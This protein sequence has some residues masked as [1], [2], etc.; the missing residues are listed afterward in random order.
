MKTLPSSPASSPAGQT[1]K[2]PFWL[3]ALLALVLLLILLGLQLAE[4]HFFL[5]DDNV[6]HFLPAYD[7]AYN[8]V[9]HAGE[10]PLLNHHQMFGGTFLASG[11][12]GVFLF[13][14]YPVHAAFDLLG[15]DPIH[16]IDVLAT[17][18][19]WLAG[20]GMGWLLRSWK[21]RPALAFPLALCWAL[22]PFGVVA[23]RS[24]VFVTF[25]IAYLPINLGLLQ[26]CLISPSAAACARLLAVKVVFFYTGYLHYAILA[27]FFEACFLFL[28]WLR[29]PHAGLRQQVFMMAAV[30]LITLLLTAPLLVTTWNAK[31]LS[32]QRDQPIP[33]DVAL[34][35][36]LSPIETLKAHFFASDSNIYYQ[37]SNAIFFTGPLWLV[38]LL[39]GWRFWRNL[40]ERE[41][42]SSLALASTGIFALLMSTSLYWLLYQLPIFNVLRWPFKGFP[43]AAF[44]LLLPAAS[45]LA[46]WAAQRPHR[47]YLAAGLVWLNLLLELAVLAPTHWRAPIGDWQFERTVKELRASPFLRAISDQ[48]RVA[49]LAADSD[50]KEKG[51]PLALG[52]LYATLFGKYHVHGYDPLK[53]R[54][55]VELGYQIANDGEM[56]VLPGEWPKLFPKLKARYLILHA[57]SDLLAEVE[58]TPGVQRL[59]TAEGLV[60]FEN[61]EALPIVSRAEEGKPIPFRW[62]TNGLELDLPPDFPGGHLLIVVAGLKGYRWYLDGE[63][64]GEPE[65]AYQLPILPV[66]PGAGHVELRYHDRGFVLGMALCMLGLL[67][68]LA[69]LRRGDA[70][71]NEPR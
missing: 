11:Q 58:T 10:I 31:E 69:G 60:L 55:N 59:K 61:L 1:S 37:L 17:L 8:T 6:T 32:W 7:Y 26:R 23:G 9:V 53:A 38:G 56:R 51:R 41:S 2:N 3:G 29:R 20:L 21:I 13:V 45:A 18:H 24:W 22:L 33:E 35:S 36:P 71:L 57:T 54:I 16:L 52:F 62:R 34:A 47:I 14:L 63:D 64:Q 65:L 70:W 19:L 68:T 15:I 5:R 67:A 25:L 40:P 39:L 43:I 4:P 48:G 42:Q 49:L 50:P 44:F 66:P 46:A 12:T 28:H 27:S 30:Y